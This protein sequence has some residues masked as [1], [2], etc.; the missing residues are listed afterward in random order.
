MY[1]VRL[2]TLQFHW[3]TQINS[4][5][6]IIVSTFNMAVSTCDAFEEC[7]QRVLNGLQEKGFKLN[8]KSEQ[9]KAIRHLYEGRDLL[10]VLP[11]GYGKSLIFQIL[12]LKNTKK[13]SPTER[14]SSLLFALW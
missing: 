8:L 1:S 6:L 5:M 13:C 9:M 7:I 2:R 10:A 4:H 3:L 12:M 11:T 14:H